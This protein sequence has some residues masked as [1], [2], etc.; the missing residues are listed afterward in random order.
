[1]ATKLNKAV[2]R[3]IELRGLPP[4][5]RGAYLVKLYPRATIGLRRKRHKKELFVSMMDIYRLACT[6]EADRVRAEKA[7]KRR[8][9]RR[10]TQ[11][12]K[13]RTKR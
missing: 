8:G 2:C 7:E 6:R 13:R 10:L 4:A 12:G 5:D 11:R 1:M 3:E 9:A